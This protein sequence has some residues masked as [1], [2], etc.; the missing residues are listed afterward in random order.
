MK[1]SLPILFLIILAVVFIGLG[2]LRR[3]QIPVRSIAVVPKHT[4][5]DFW[6][7]VHKGAKKAGAET[8]TIIFWKAPP[9][10]DGRENQIRIVNDFIARKTA[11]I[12]L[13]PL[14]SKAL[15]GVVKKAY[16]AKIPC[17][18]IDSAVGT[19]KYTSFIGT[20]HFKGGARAARHMGKLLNGKG[21]AAV[22]SG[23]DTAAEREHGFIQTIQREFKGI[24]IAKA[25]SNPGTVQA[26]LQAAGDVLSKNKKLDGIF[27]C[28]EITAVGVLQA[29]RNQN[30]A[31]A[32]KMVGFDSSAL[33]LAA[34]ED[35]TID[36]LI[37]PDPFAMGY[38]AVNVILAGLNGKKIKRRIDTGTV[39]VTKENLKTRAVQNLIH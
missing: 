13:A 5:H 32:V 6:K 19:D 36:A 27:A 20:D 31:G 30:R 29:L 11:G 35:G 10:K 18:I 37:V 26:A 22:I 25:K 24:S 34:L 2:I 16:A 17:V 9:R 14:D 7:A 12:V 28:D 39:L 1:R 15:T 21:R 33:L 4:A 38:K 3:A 8:G 23:P